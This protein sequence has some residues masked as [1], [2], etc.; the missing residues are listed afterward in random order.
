MT[1]SRCH[2]PYHHFLYAVDDD[3]ATRSSK[4][5]RRRG[6]L[7]H[8]MLEIDMNIVVMAL[9]PYF[10]FHAPITLLRIPAT[11]A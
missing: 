11:W 2:L 8:G 3:S 6:T 1:M 10:I 9:L 7:L 5:G 4:F